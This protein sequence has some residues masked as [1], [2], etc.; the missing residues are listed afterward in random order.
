VLRTNIDSPSLL[1][2]H[3]YRYV[4]MLLDR[5]AYRVSELIISHGRR[6]IPIPASV[7]IDWKSQRGH[8]S[9]KEIGYLAGLG[10]RGKNN[11]L[12]H[13]RYGSSLRLVTVLT[14]CELP[15]SKPVEQDCGSC[16]ACQPHCP[17]NAIKESPED[18]DRDRCFQKVEEFSKKIGVGICGL[19]LNR[20]PT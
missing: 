15:L 7:I 2:K 18:F 1:Y 6:A 19:C 12:V 8:L 10:W 11:L 4:N 13:K 3:H 20:C 14:D 16:N 5:I 9:H 17:V